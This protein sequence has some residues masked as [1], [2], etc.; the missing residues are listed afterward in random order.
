MFAA[1]DDP[2][3]RERWLP[4]VE[5]A[6]RTT[7]PPRLARYDWEGGPSRLVLGIEALEDGRSRVGLSHERLA[8]NAERDRL[9]P[10]WRERLTA[11]KELLEE[12]GGRGARITGI[13]DMGPD[14]VVEATG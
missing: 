7:T 1:F 9:K 8:D 3:S 10:W 14:G 12:G 5:L 4:G 11:L 6:V 13:H 2:A